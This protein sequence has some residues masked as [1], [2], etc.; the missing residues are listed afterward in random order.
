MS[1]LCCLVY[2][3]S[4]VRE[5]SRQDIHHLLE[6]AQ[7]RNIECQVTGVLLYAAGDFM[8]YLEGP[9]EGV[10]EVYRHIRA[11]PLHTGLIELLREP[12]G[13]REFGEW[14][15]AYRVLGV[16][17]HAEPWLQRPGLTQRI[18]G[19]DQPASPARIL[20]RSFWNRMPGRC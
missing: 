7:A 15:M 18:I 16:D 12:I 17:H 20:L 4:A 6:R 5:L 19:P 8:Q 9:E 2:V 13:Q 11:D 1:P 3:S 10:A 14:R